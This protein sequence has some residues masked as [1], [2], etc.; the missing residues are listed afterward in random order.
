MSEE[1][2]QLTVS[3]AGKIGGK[4]VKEKYGHEFY[5]E[6]GRKGGEATKKNLA[7]DPDFY[8][9]LG[10][11]GGKK[12]GESTRDKYG[13]AFYEQIGAKGGKIVKELVQEAK[14]ARKKAEEA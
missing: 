3:E 4:R 12:G 13:P 14:A 1:E 5:V 11:K 9:R 2:K 7:N 10:E 8:K 6:I